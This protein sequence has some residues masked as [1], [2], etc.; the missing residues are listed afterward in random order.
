MGDQED[1]E[2]FLEG[3]TNT[4]GTQ[5]PQMAVKVRFQSSPVWSTAVLLK[6]GQH[7]AGLMPQPF[8][9]PSFSRCHVCA[10]QHAAALLPLTFFAC[11]HSVEHLVPVTRSRTTSTRSLH[12]LSVAVIA[13]LLLTALRVHVPSD[14]S[15]KHAYHLLL[16]SILMW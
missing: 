14:R 4:A 12:L 16:L 10:C 8:A 2:A 7:Q 9:R 6:A 15:H 5:L 13:R 11:S 1:E 3:V